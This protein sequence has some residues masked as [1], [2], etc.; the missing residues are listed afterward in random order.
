MIDSETKRPI[1]SFRVIPGNRYDAPDPIW[2]RQSSMVATDGHYQFQSR[3]DAPAYLFRVEADGY[4]PSESRD[5]KSTAGK[6]WI[7]FELTKGQDIDGIVLTPDGLPAAG[8]KVA[9][10]VA[11]SQIIMINGD[12]DS[13]STYAARQETDR[14]GR[15]HFPPP[16]GGCYLVISHPSGYAQYQPTLKS[17]RRVIHLDPWTRV[18]G[19]YRIGGKPQANIE[20][21]INRGDTM[22]YGVHV[23]HISTEDEATTGPDGRF[24]FERV[25]AGNGWIG[26]RIVFMV[27]SGAGEVTWSHSVPLKFPLGKTIHV[28]LGGNGRTVSGKLQAPAGF[29]KEVKWS[30]ALVDVVPRAAGAAPPKAATGPVSAATALFASTT[31]R[32]ANTPSRSGTTNTLGDLCATIGSWFQKMKAASHCRH[33][34]WERSHYKESKPSG[35]PIIFVGAQPI[36]FRSGPVLAPCDRVCSSSLP[37]RRH[38]RRRRPRPCSRN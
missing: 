32:R 23:A 37:L 22:V 30:F 15:F 28:D 18:E 5:I 25:M 35:P 14:T 29:K 13:Q 19:V 34:T 9:M 33:S 8:A 20:I 10:G 21:S 2:Q 17:N 12:V 6:V 1:K 4:L 7:D 3:Y 36:V 11:G 27:N 16:G 38:V 26:R 24:V 31:C